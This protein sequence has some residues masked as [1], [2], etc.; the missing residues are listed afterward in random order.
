[1]QP[2]PPANPFA[3]CSGPRLPLAIS[4][5][6]HRNRKPW[7]DPQYS[8]THGMQYMQPSQVIPP[9][10]ARVVVPVLP[11]YQRFT[12]GPGIVDTTSPTVEGEM[13]RTLSEFEGIPPLPV[14]GSTAA[15]PLPTPFW[16]ITDD[17]YFF[18]GGLSLITG[19]AGRDAVASGM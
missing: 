2:V 1:M 15:V 18:V 4:D 5:V 3:T 12:R 19:R 14:G 8:I 16:Q 17:L 9:P 10:Q 13:R 11:S 7:I 6:P